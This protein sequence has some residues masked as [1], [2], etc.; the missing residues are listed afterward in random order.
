[1][2]KKPTDNAPDADI[3]K[4]GFQEAGI[5]EGIIYGSIFLEDSADGTVTLSPAGA[6]T[7]ATGGNASAAVGGDC[8]SRRAIQRR[9]RSMQLRRLDD[10]Q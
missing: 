1:M 2:L 10:K 7:G 8:A 3:T 9:R 6:A 4:E 5:N